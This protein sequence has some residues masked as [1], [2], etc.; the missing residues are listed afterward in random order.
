M[1]L[2]F[3]LDRARYP[4]AGQRRHSGLLSCRAWLIR[5]GQT[6]TGQAAAAKQGNKAL[7]DYNAIMHPSIRVSLW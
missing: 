4:G 1:T 3:E 5:S 7:F 6:Q 2:G